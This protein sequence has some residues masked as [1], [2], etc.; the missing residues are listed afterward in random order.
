MRVHGEK[1]DRLIAIIHILLN[2]YIYILKLTF[3]LLFS[4]FQNRFIPIAESVSLLTEGGKKKTIGY[5]NS[6]TNLQRHGKTQTKK[7]L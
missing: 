6:K 2:R 3:N 1:P 5:S 4:T 7:D